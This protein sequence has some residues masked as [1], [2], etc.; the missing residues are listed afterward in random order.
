MR[1][2]KITLTGAAQQITT[3]PKLYASTLIIQCNGAAGVW[4]GDN[5]VAANNGVYLAPAA[6]PPGG[7]SATLPIYAPHGTHL[8]DYY[9][10]GTATQIVNVLYENAQ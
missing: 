5:T 2:I 7:G 9:V 6:S 1:C 10:L 8:I 3:D 4:V